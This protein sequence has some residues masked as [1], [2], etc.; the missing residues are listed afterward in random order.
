MPESVSL[1]PVTLL[2]MPPVTLLITPEYRATF[3]DLDDLL[4]E[5]S[6]RDGLYVVAMN[7]RA[8]QD[9]GI[10]ERVLVEAFV[11]TPT[12]EWPLRLISG[13]IARASRERLRAAGRS[14][15]GAGPF[16]LYRGVAGRRPRRRVRGFSWTDSLEVARRFAT[17]DPTLDDPA[18]YKVLVEGAHV[19]TYVGGEEGEYLVLLPG[20]TRPV[21]I[22]SPS[23]APARR[24]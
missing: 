2:I 24:R 15:P 13:L 19:L 9:A 20:T 11:G 23:G 5:I 8:L 16:R 17:R 22:E 4:L 7:S 12:Q 21:R 1:V 6:N 10:Y 3:Y 14:L 18:V